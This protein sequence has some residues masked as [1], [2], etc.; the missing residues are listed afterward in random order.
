M[1]Y[2]IRFHLADEKYLAKYGYLV[3]RYSIYAI[4]PPKKPLKFWVE[5]T[6][7]RIYKL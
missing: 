4:F 2:K 3:E 6:S 5:D 7:V 1:G